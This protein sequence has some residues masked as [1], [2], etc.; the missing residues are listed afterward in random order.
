MLIPDSTM[1][2]FV[3]AVTARDEVTADDMKE[4]LL[5]GLQRMVDNYGEIYYL[6]VLETGVDNFT[7]GSWMQDAKAGLKHFTKWTKIAVV[8]DQGGVEKFTDFFSFAL[9]GKSRGFKM[10][11]LEDAKIWISTREN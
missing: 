3:F 7:A 2:S 10:A 8:T 9:P 1:P 5:P 4:V 6:L 11:E